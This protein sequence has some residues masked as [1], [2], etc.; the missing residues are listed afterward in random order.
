MFLYAYSPDMVRTDFK[1]KVV[2]FIW[3]GK[4]I[5]Y[6]TLIQDTGSGSIKPF[7]FRVL[8]DSF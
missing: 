6:N 8:E 7:I 5:V 4:K 2:D 1:I 3:N